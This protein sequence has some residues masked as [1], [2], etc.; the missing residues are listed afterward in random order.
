MEV[1]IEPRGPRGPDL[2]GINGTSMVGEIKHQ[3][4]LHRHLSSFYWSSWNSNR[5]FG[6]KEK[7]FKLRSILPESAESLPGC[8]KGWI[9]A[10][11][12]QLKYCTQEENLTEG[13]L[14]YEDYFSFED[15]LLEALSFLNH[16]NL[17]YNETPEHLEKVGFVKIEYN[18]SFTLLTRREA[19]MKKKDKIK[20][21]YEFVQLFDRMWGI[22]TKYKDQVIFYSKE[23]ARKIRL[24]WEGKSIAVLGPQA[25][26]KT[27]LFRVLQDS[28]AAIDVMDYVATTEPVA[29]SKKMSVEWKL[30]LD[31]NGKKAEVVKL[32]IRRPKDVGGEKSFRDT[33]GAWD[34]I[35]EDADFLFYL[36]DI[37][38]LYDDKK[39]I[40]NRLK[41]D[42]E[43]LANNAQ[44]FAA[45]F[46][47]IIFANKIDLVN[48]KIL[49]A[50]EQKR[51]LDKELP[52]IEHLARDALGPYKDHL[53]MITPC[54]LLSVKGRTNSI[55]LA[56][57]YLA[58]LP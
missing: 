22:L 48:A 9:A 58:E 13:W 33:R 38:K 39:N 49:K 28:S 26:G 5:K 21:V 51:F 10:I 55:S 23:V 37:S 16:Q 14:V 25:A 44:R 35:C 11:Y 46:R 2:E 27:T 41:E 54:C 1:S 15:G 3:I 31:D 4:E 45:G 32:K 6:G 20:Q 34:Q 53:T 17:T 12:G 43:W 42:F 30:P 29:I 7:D 40:K 8:V 56:M 57:R 47:M 19:Y 50:E 18:Q 36:F 52:Q 24:R